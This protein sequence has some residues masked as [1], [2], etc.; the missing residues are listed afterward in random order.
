M[1]AALLR[2][3]RRTGPRLLA[4]VALALLL[5]SVG[6]A[7]A[8]DEARRVLLGLD[9]FPNVLSVDEE[10][11]GKTTVE[12]RLRILLLHREMPD[13]AERLAASLREKVRTIKKIPVEVV[14]GSAAAAPFADANRPCGIFLAELLPDREFKS[15]LRLAEENH[16]ILFSP[17][18]GDMERG[19]TAGLHISSKIRPALNT[20]TLR[21]SNIRI[22]EMFLRL[23][24]LYD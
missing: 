6:A 20:T 2:V 21:R 7:A 18:E 5:P 22:H 12:G 3:L 19:A 9:F 24:R 10:I 1:G 15:V 23:S 17:F 16:V 14:V 13:A 4:P 8:R 11:A